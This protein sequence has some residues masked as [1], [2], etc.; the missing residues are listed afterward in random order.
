MSDNQ[1]TRHMVPA[2]TVISDGNGRGVPC[3]EPLLVDSKQ[4]A[5]MLSIGRS[6]FYAMLSSGRI[7]PMSYKLGKRTLYSVKELRE[8]VEA[9]MPPR[10]KWIAQNN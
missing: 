7:G 6:H 10:Q 4:A 2:A 1:S 3:P 5:A 9:G 8:W